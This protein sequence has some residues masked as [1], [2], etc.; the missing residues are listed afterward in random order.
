MKTRMPVCVLHNE[1][2]PGAG[3]AEQDVLVQTDEITAILERLGHRVCRLAA[4]L[5]CAAS[6]T[7]LRAHS[8]AVVFNL[9][10]SLAG[11]D[12]LIHVYPALLE[13]EG[14]PFTGSSAEALFLSSNKILAK[15]L[16]ASAGI[17][18]PG[19]I[20]LQQPLPA[21][22]TPGTYIIKSA[23]EHASAGLEADCVIRIISQD[24]AGAARV[25]FAQRFKHGRFFAEAF[26]EGR[27]FNISILDGPDGPEVLAPAEIIFTN[28]GGSPAIVG[29]RA[30]WSE[31]SPE[32]MN[33]QRSFAFDTI[34]RKLLDHLCTCALACWREFS[35]RGYARVDFRVDTHNRPWVLEINANPC[36]SSDAGFMAAAAQSGYDP[37][38]VIDRI[39]CAAVQSKETL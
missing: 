35:L 2:P 30:K 18:T 14:I 12:A 19:F 22:I 4:G 31:S 1:V 37:D 23:T 39:M 9:V 7:A 16:M 20:D 17:P 36:L 8:P 21:T 29:Y 32:Y 6:L 38:T 28:F 13:A 15:R 34:D 26:I 27:E 3:P 33:T 24:N 10:E 5:D 25:K 11:S